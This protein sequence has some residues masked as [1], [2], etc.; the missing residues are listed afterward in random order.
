M[1]TEALIR[2]LDALIAERDSYK[3]AL[4]EIACFFPSASGATHYNGPCHAACVALR[5]LDH[6]LPAGAA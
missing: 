2:D 5:A 1:N 6:D 3:A 4:E